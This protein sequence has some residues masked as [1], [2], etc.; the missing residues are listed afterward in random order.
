MIVHHTIKQLLSYDRQEKYKSTILKRL[1]TTK[2]THAINERA[3]ARPKSSDRKVLLSASVAIVKGALYVM[4]WYSHVII[5]Q[6][7]TLIARLIRQVLNL[8]LRFFTLSLSGLWSSLCAASSQVFNFIYWR[9]TCTS[10]HTCTMV[11]LISPAQ[12]VQ[13]HW[14]LLIIRLT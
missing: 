13:S 11:R 9:R 8:L 5:L 7:F 10:I 4:L 3:R 14:R 2:I 12:H 1:D 6:C